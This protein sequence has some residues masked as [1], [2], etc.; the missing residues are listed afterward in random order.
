MLL[1]VVDG[2]IAVK[3]SCAKILSMSRL[4]IPEPAS[5]ISANGN[6]GNNN[7]PLKSRVKAF[8]DNCLKKTTIA[9]Y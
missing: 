7:N 9:F 3:P 1:Q 6:N 5:K 2:R 8:T 4:Q